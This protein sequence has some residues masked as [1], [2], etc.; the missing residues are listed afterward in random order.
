MQRTVHQ[1]IPGNSKR[2]I[3]QTKTHNYYTINQLAVHGNSNNNYW[4]YNYS[5]LHT[6]SEEY[7]LTFLLASFHFPKAKTNW[8][9]C[10]V[11]KDRWWHNFLLL[12]ALLNLVLMRPGARQ[13]TLISSAASSWANTFV[14]PKRA[15]LLTE[16]GPS[17]CRLVNFFC[18]SD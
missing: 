11:L 2:L 8:D 14:S 5:E 12:T 7:S 15:V 16:Y 18:K 1:S 10:T 9:T 4:S 13:F 17:I 6:C 3:A